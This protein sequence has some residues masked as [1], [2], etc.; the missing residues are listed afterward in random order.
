MFEVNGV[1]FTVLDKINAVGKLK[2]QGA[3]V[4]Q[5]VFCGGYKAAHVINMCEYIGRCDQARLAMQAGWRPRT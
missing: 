1:E 3:V 4:A 5:A 2:H